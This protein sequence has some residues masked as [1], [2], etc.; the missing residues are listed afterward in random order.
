[1]LSAIVYQLKTGSIKRVF[2]KG[3]VSVNPESPYIVVWQ[4]PLIP[5]PGYDNRGKN[6]YKIAVHYQKG[7]VN[8]LDDY[9]FNEIQILLHKKRLL[10]RD[11]RYVTIYLTGYVST[12]IEGNDD[13]TI[14]KERECITAGIYT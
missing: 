11:N 3:S 6:S 9:V 5:Q 14:S 13:G 4:D 7:F 1:M 12:L 10:T 8:Q 2:P